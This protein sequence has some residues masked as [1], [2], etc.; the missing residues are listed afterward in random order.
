MFLTTKSLGELNKIK[1]RGIDMTKKEL[2]EVFH[3]QKEIQDLQ[4]RINTVEKQSQIVSDVVQNG[5]KGRTV[6]Q[7]IDIK[8]AYKLDCAYE[9]LKKFKLMLI[10]KQQHIEDYIESIPF[11]EMRQIFRYRYL[12]HKNWIQIAHKMNDVYHGKDYTENSVRHKH[13]RFLEKM[14]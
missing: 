8:R 5:Y 6:I 7:G 9:K 3:I 14:K 2:E 11:S 13:D 1:Q 10:Q 4:K 12:D